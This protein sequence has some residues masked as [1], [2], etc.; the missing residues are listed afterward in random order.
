MQSETELEKI[1][2]IEQKIKDGEIT[3]FEYSEFHNV[4]KIGEGGFGKVY[5]ADAINHHSNGIEVV[6]L[7]KFKGLEKSHKFVKEV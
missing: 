5:K 3:Y 6:A 4:E 7:K 2:K 1:E